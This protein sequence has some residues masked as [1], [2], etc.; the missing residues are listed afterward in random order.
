MLKGKNVLLG[1]SAG[2]A[3]YKAAHL[4][5][6]LVKKGANV[7]VLMTPDSA[8][9]ITPLTLSTLSKNPVA[10]DYFDERTGEW[11]NHVELAKWA[12]FFLLAPATANTLAKMANGLC[13]NVLLATYFSI[14]DQNSVFFAPA[15]DLDM[16]NH[17][18]IQK[19]ISKLQ[20]FG[21]QLIPAEEGELAS[22]LQG[23]G[24]M[25]EVD[26][27]LQFVEG[28][29]QG[30]WKG[31]KLLITAGPTYESIDPVRFIGNHSSGKMGY[32]LAEAAVKRGAAVT[33]ISGPTQIELNAS[34]KLIK[35][36]SAQEM[37][38][39]VKAHYEEANCLIFSA[40]VSDYRPTT[41]AEKKIKKKSSELQIDLQPTP[42]ILKYVGE[43]KKAAQFLVGFALETDNEK[44]NA[45]GKLKRKNLDLIVLN[46][47]NDQGAGF[48]H[49]SNKVT[50][51]DANNNEANFE[52]KS[53]AMV[54]EDILNAIESRW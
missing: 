44:E 49:D 26:H 30:T 54:A 12:D 46:S 38:E 14:P 32:A 27:I 4:C 47:L 21:N 43:H 11:E 35:V 53:K 29:L 37:F 9:F 6:A 22:G 50:L 42:D 18:A 31:K 28:S 2:I 34:L 10:I 24:R 48:G 23:K 41:S 7:K 16:H 40:A 25:A 52:L 45:K 1:V 36:T 15:M 19:N 13:D 20:S 5:R 33:L 51:L 3:A 17:P 39:A 8:H